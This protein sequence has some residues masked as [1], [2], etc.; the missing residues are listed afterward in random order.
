MKFVFQ[1]VRYAARSLWKAPLFTAVAVASLAVGIGATTA[2]YGAVDA[3]LLRPFPAVARP[4]Q[5][6]VLTRVHPRHATDPV[7]VN[8]R[9]SKGVAFDEYRQLRTTTGAVFSG[10]FAHRAAQGVELEID[11][12]TFPGQVDFVSG[13]YFQTL[14]LAPVRGRLLSDDDEHT[15]GQAPVAVLSESMWRRRFGSAADVLGRRITV[16]HIAFTIVGV[17]PR[18]FRG[19]DLDDVHDVFLPL[20][21]AQALRSDGFTLFGPGAASWFDLVGR[22]REGVTRQQAA[23][24]PALQTGLGEGGRIRLEP[25][26]APLADDNRERF[27]SFSALVMAAAAGTIVMAC[28][29]IAGLLLARAA[30]RRREIA[31]RGALGASRTRLAQQLLTE[32]VVLAAIGGAGSLLVAHGLLHV[33]SAFTLPGDI[34]AALLDLHLDTRALIVASLLTFGTSLAFGLLPTWHGSKV[35]LVSGMKAVG[36]AGSGPG[37]LVRRF[38]LA[39]QIAISLPLLTGLMLCVRS[40]QAVLQT[41]AGF[42]HERLAVVE[43]SGGTTPR[44]SEVTRTLLARTSHLAEIERADL[45]SD[46]QRAFVARALIV[47]GT[48][49]DFES[50]VSAHVIGPEYFDVLG[51]PIRRGRAIDRGDIAGSPMV[52]VVNE[53]LAQTLW[54]SSEALGRR[55]SYSTERGNANVF[56]V[57]GVSA[58]ARYLSLGSPSKP[59]FYLSLAQVP[60]TPLTL[61]F[62]ARG[63]VAHAVSAV[64]RELREID[65][66]LPPPTVVAAKEALFRLSETQRLGTTLLGLF[67]V[68]ALGLSSIGLY[69]LLAYSVSRQTA[70]IGVRMAMGADRRAI[71]ALFLTQGVR[72][73]VPGLIVGSLATVGLQGLIG[74]LLHG[75]SP[76]DPPS[77]GVAVLVLGASA[78]AASWLPARRAARVHPAEALRSE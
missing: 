24:H 32:S 75:V 71:T 57:V 53:A 35:D 9:R 49:R 29:N 6:V 41:D 67:G 37:S 7:G 40:L 46:F 59:R 69:G 68:T 39:G 21:M 8:E 17:A 60:R 78:I 43:V 38:A 2:I 52:A 70:A 63:D 76:D 51:L 77:F 25:I 16:N 28:A 73:I 47:D 74:K 5:L 31:L 18:G 3:V 27:A 14:G 30:D 55:F 23:D 15:P 45:C 65:P 36:R 48:R 34:D 26:T 42:D 72:I 66:S 62:R 33:L 22:L 61:L 58:N 54:P 20:T 10:I 50:N 4:E 64:R 19:L 13:G 12:E 44:H 56:E 1:D 11:G